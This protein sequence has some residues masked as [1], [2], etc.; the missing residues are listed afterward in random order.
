MNLITRVREVWQ[1]RELVRN[2]VIRDLKV[3]YKNS[4]LGIA[5]SWL[6][7][8]LMMVVYTIL[9]TVLLRNSDIPRY[10]VFL[11]SGLLAWNFFSDTVMQATGSIVGNAHLLKKVY[12]PPDVLPISLLLANLVNFLIALPLF[13]GLALLF[14]IRP[15]WAALLLPV[16]L[17]IQ[18][19]F[20][21]GVSF[22]L[23]TLNVFFRDTQVILGVIM[24]AWFFLTPV[25][26]T[27]KFVPEHITVLG[28]TVNAQLWLRRLNPMA[29]IIASYRDLLYWGVP[30][31]LDFLLRTAATALVSLVTGYA[32]FTRYSHRFSEEV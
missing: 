18:V 29:S 4:L 13:F 25:F 21:L 1:Y 19:V 6:N 15:T 12:F 5:W 9:F 20:T 22:L 8:L 24:L 11:L 27:I 17:L 23:A 26:Y 10:P 31:G 7:P 28:V 16:T 32:V 2:L 14:G 30:T 3:R